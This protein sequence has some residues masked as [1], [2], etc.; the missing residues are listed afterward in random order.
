MHEHV[1]P[2]AG[3]NKEELQQNLSKNTLEVTE[4][5]LRFIAYKEPGA[6][7]LH[8]GNIQNQSQQILLKTCYYAKKCK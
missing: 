1:F 2:V 6:V 4:L 5:L 3:C 7:S 8:N